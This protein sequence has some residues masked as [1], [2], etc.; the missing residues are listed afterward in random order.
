MFALKQRTQVPKHFEICRKTLMVQAKTVK[1]LKVLA[2]ECFVQYSI[3]F[4]A[5]C[6]ATCQTLSR[7]HLR[8]LMKNAI[9]F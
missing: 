7:I 9:Y 6:V 2:L 8:T 1:T 3:N 4:S 5:E